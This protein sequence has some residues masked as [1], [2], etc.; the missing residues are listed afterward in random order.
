VIHA[1]IRHRHAALSSLFEFMILFNAA[2]VGV[3]WER[4]LVLPLEQPLVAGRG[5]ALGARWRG[6]YARN[7][8]EYPGSI[9]APTADNKAPHQA[10]PAGGGRRIR[11]PRSSATGSSVLR[12]IG[13]AEWT[14][15]LSPAF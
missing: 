13:A 5:A 10:G 7:S 9:A 11:T 8:S 2:S 15:R 12:G 4:L 3:Y 14:P 6:R 1:S